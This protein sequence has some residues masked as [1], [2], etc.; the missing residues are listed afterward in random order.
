LPKPS[1]DV[2]GTKPIDFEILLAKI[3]GCVARLGNDIR[4]DRAF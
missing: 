2:E 1:N 4:N 3:E